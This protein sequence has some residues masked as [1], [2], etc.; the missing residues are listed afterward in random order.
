VPYAISFAQE[1]QARLILLHVTCT[2]DL[3]VDF[4]QRERSVANTM[5]ELHELVPKDAELWCRPEAVVEYGETAARILEAAKERN[6]DMIVLGVR[7]GQT[8]STE[9]THFPHSI[10]Y[11]VVAEAACPVLTVRG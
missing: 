6:A 1:H 8:R 9:I 2:P 4:R 3:R 7:S 10:G 5:H 11:K